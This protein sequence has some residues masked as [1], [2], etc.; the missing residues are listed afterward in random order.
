MSQRQGKELASFTQR[1]ASHRDS[2]ES[3]MVTAELAIAI[4]PV[5]LI[6]IAALGALGG[7]LMSIDVHAA[8]A[9]IA[10][11]ASLGAT[12]AELDTLAESVVSGSTVTA[13]YQN[14]YV[15]VTLSATPPAH[16]RWLGT[17]AADAHAM[18]EPGAA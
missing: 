13:E 4:I 2:T 18:I 1:P 15:H 12:T 3:G 14:G 6:L 10:R 16:L 8:V 11:A 17:I 9:V 7:V 5:M